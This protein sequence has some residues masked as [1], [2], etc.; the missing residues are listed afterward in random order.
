M[1]EASVNTTGCRPAG[2]DSVIPVRLY[3][4]GP[5]KNQGAI[6][7]LSAGEKGVA[8]ADDARSS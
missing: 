2:E 7:A 1:L 3:R 6:S 8:A 5:G 4:V